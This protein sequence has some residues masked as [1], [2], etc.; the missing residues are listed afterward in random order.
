MFPILCV[1]LLWLLAQPAAAS[2]PSPGP[3]APRACTLP[4]LSLSALLSTYD[5]RSAARSQQSHAEAQARRARASAWLPQVML[6]AE[7]RRFDNRRRDQALVSP[8]TTQ[9]RQEQGL[10]LRAQLRWELNQL[11]HHH[12]SL[13]ALRLAQNLAQQHAK[14]R[15]ALAQSFVRWQL[16]FLKS[17]SGAAF[18]AKEREQC[19]LLRAQILVATG[20]LLPH[21]FP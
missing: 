13:S 5:A 1:L 6:S 12:A 14:A 21:A 20:V 10:V 19:E 9:R 18:S 8:L 17:C 3:I 2:S 4:A 16:L 11:V 7:H 15:S